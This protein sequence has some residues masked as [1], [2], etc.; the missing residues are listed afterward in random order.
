MLLSAF[1]TYNLVRSDTQPTQ[2]RI[3]QI[4][5]NP[6]LDHRQPDRG[7]LGGTKTGANA[8]GLAYV[9]TYMDLSSKEERERVFAR[10]REKILKAVGLQHLA[11][12]DNGIIRSSAT[13]RGMNMPEEDIQMM[14]VT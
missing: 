12:V 8:W 6:S 2:S 13:S 5:L 14:D 1:D 9:D 4:T 10:K 11:T 7:I 3:E